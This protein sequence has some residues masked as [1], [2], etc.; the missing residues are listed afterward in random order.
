MFFSLAEDGVTERGTVIK[1]V[2][3]GGGGGNAINRMIEFG[4]EGVE[5][6]ACNTDKQVLMN[7]KAR[8]KI[9][10]GSSV[11]RGLGAGGDP[12]VGAAAAEEEKETI[13]NMLNGADMVFITA[14]MGGGT[15][16]GAAPVIA[17]IAKEVGALTVAV[18]SKPF[19]FEGKKKMEMAMAGIEKLRKNVDTLI[20]IPNEKIMSIMGPKAPIK[21]AFLRADDVL[22]MGIQG[23]T[24]IITLP[25]E[26][27]IDFADVRATMDGKGD[28]LIGIGKG[29]GENKAMQA[30][31]T[32]I[33][34]P[35]LEDVTLNGATRLLINVVGSSDFTLEDYNEV[36]SLITSSVDPSCHIIS[37]LAFRDSLKDEIIITVIATGFQKPEGKLGF[38]VQQ[39]TNPHHI[40]DGTTA[41]REIG[42]ASLFDGMVRPGIDKNYLGQ[43]RDSGNLDIPTIL[44]GAKILAGKN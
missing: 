39:T 41:H 23:I 6:L 14:G 4:L 36:N 32:I 13:R 28:A 22:R 2:G 37:G 35:L 27:N 15:G 31:Q 38:E 40:M 9:V 29:S 25:G 33:S 18:V 8:D 1:V 42:A 3:V 10:L 7:N 34:N 30:V 16:T 17:K 43:L 21:E 5:F 24:E 44:R 26:I 20:T 19:H 11:S 12:E